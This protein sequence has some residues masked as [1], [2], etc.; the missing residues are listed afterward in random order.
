MNIKLCCDVTTSGKASFLPNQLL[1][2]GKSMKKGILLLVLCFVL[3]I[4]LS[5]AAI[6]KYG[7]IDLSVKVPDMIL[8][9]NYRSGTK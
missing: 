5:M 9:T 4:S 8:K 6:A 2:K 1:V 7:I 3:L